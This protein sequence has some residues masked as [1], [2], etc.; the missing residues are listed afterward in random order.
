MRAAN[1]PLQLLFFSLS[2]WNVHIG[3]QYVYAVISLS[4]LCCSGEHSKEKFPKAIVTAQKAN[5]SQ[6]D[7]KSVQLQP[8]LKYRI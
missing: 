8:H 2:S 1:G 7:L 6:T 3:D 4:Y 5:P